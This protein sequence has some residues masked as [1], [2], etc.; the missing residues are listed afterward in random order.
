MGVSRNT[1]YRRFKSR[2]H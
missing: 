1:L 2:G